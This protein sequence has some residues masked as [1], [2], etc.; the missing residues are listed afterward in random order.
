MVTALVSWI[1][2]GKW[3]N[4]CIVFQEYGVISN[5]R[6][7]TTCQTVGKVDSWSYT[8]ENDFMFLTTSVYVSL[9]FYVSVCVWFLPTSQLKGWQG[10]NSTLGPL[11]VY[12]FT[13]AM[14]P[15]NFNLLNKAQC[16]YFISLLVVP[17]TFI[18]HNLWPPYDPPRMWSFILSSQFKQYRYGFNKIISF[19]IYWFYKRKK[20]VALASVETDHLFLFIDFVQRIYW[21]NTYKIVQ[22]LVVSPLSKNKKNAYRL[23]IYAKIL[24][25]FIDRMCAYVAV[26]IQ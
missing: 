24:S 11:S 4:V 15:V 20:N 12:M 3:V 10:Y 18:W 16:S 1:T 17:S 5:T 25:C 9:W 19:K 6:L 7:I 26:Q 14:L 22:P 8:N 2:V 13:T 21:L 23:L